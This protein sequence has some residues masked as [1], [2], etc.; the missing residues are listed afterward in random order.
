MVGVLG[1][2]RVMVVIMAVEGGMVLLIIVHRTTDHHMQDLL[3]RDLHL[4]VHLVIDLLQEGNARHLL[5]EGL[6]KYQKMDK[7]EVDLLRLIERDQQ[8]MTGQTCT[9]KEMTYDQVQDHQQAWRGNQIHSS[10]H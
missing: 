1:F 8:L 6:V 3:I 7:E 10:L 9:D 4:I 2:M 5:E